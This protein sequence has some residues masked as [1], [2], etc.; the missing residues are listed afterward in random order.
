MRMPSLR[1]G[2]LLFALGFYYELER[3]PTPEDLPEGAL[4]Y[5]SNTATKRPQEGDGW[6]LA[7]RAAGIRLYVPAESDLRS[8]ASTR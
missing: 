2:S 6:L 3:V 4:L 5:T 8:L 7:W 1:G